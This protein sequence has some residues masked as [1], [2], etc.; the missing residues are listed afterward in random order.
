MFSF[1]TIFNAEVF[2]PP[3]PDFP[4][5]AFKTLLKSRLFSILIS[6]RGGIDLRL[7]EDLPFQSHPLERWVDLARLMTGLALGGIKLEIRSKIQSE[8]SEIL[9]DQIE[10]T[11]DP[12]PW[13][14][15]LKLCEFASHLLRVAGVSNDFS[16]RVED[17][18]A[19]GAQIFEAGALL[20]GQVARVSFRSQLAGAEIGNPARGVLIGCVKIGAVRITYYA[21]AE[22][23]LENGAG[24]TKWTSTCITSGR[25]RIITESHAAFGSFVE[26][27]KE[28]AAT[29]ISI[30]LRSPDGTPGIINIA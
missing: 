10:Q 1:P 16:V 6:V 18:E 23:L 24:F 12:L 2:V 27:A 19:Q 9:I 26:Y 25:A 30:V 20:C 3:I 29:S 22:F 17:I 15:W 13:R 8:Y 28:E 21:I 7:A 4:R 11:I 5:E 14:R